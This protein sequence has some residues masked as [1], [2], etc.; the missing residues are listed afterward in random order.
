MRIFILLSRIPWPLEK[1]DKLR[2]YH[3][4]R[5]LSAKHEI[6]L[7]ALNTD[8][9]A[10]KQQAFKALQPYCRSIN[11][12]DLGICGQAVNL[13][14]AWFSGRPL[15]S[16]YFY[17]ASAQRSIRS[18]ISEYKPDLLYGQLLRVAEYLRPF[19]L[20]KALDYQDVF[21]MGMLRRLEVA[22]WY[23]KPFLRTEY[24]RLSRYEASMFECFDVK[25]I[26]SK[27]DRDLIPHEKR[28]EIMIVPNG[29]DHG[30]FK[31]Q[32][33]IKTNDVVFTGNMAYPPNVNA[34]EFL[35]RDIM[36][37]VWQKLPKTTVLLA[38]ATPDPKLRAFASEKVKVS[39]WL[40]D[41]R[42]A[43]ASSAV[44]IAPMR[45]GTGLQNK[46]LEAMSMKIPC[47]TTPIANNA[48]GG[49]EGEHLLIGTTA[50]ELAGHIISL[51]NDRQQA[52]QIAN[53]GFIFVHGNYNW[54]S[55]TGRL[56][57]RFEEL[58]QSK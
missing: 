48:L 40:N 15:Q 29:V 26:I 31:P 2:A 35:I 56:S 50:A 41:I 16:G 45:I 58:V 36:P 7:C 57:S 24:R 55:A 12:I 20:P 13:V 43:Y 23:Q 34:A 5:C 9:K 4:I 21:S 3:Q 39:G 51:L 27:P 25:T 38:G 22:P 44:F 17:S 49:T 1:G 8:R 33:Q 6:I 47:I 37:L 54:E 18:L 42:E 19:Q 14:K 11:F 10:D 52:D 28:E 53:N 46:L 32:D 30:F